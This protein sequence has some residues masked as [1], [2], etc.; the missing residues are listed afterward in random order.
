MLKEQFSKGA[1]NEDLV[2]K[3]AAMPESQL[4]EVEN[5]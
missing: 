1:P 2:W 4:F 3:I 5:G